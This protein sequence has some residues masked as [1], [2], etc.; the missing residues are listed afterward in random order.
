MST[1]TLPLVNIFSALLANRE[2]AYRDLGRMMESALLAASPLV[3]HCCSPLA[4]CPPFRETHPKY[5][6][7]GDEESL[8]AGNHRLR[9]EP[10][11]RRRHVGAFLA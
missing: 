9:L 6:T 3:A 5:E 7:V 1:Q 8:Q 2:C 4:C 11:R 10:S